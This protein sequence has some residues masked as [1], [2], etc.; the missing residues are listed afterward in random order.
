[1]KEAARGKTSELVCVQSFLQI[2]PQAGQRSPD[3]IKV[4][5]PCIVPTTSRAFNFR[6]HL[7]SALETLLTKFTYTA[8][9]C[10]GGNHSFPISLPKYPHFLFR[11]SSRRRLSL[12]LPLFIYTIA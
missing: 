11:T 12:V 4:K 8:H 1:M 7:T 2:L 6:N 9:N 5:S 3:F 10:F